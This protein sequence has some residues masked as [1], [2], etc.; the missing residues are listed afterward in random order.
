MIKV[1]VVRGIVK[2]H[3][4]VLAPHSVLSLY[5]LA[6]ISLQSPTCATISSTHPIYSSDLTI[7][8]ILSQGFFVLSP[9]MRSSSR[10]SCIL[11]EQ[12]VRDFW[13]V[14]SWSELENT[15]S[16]ANRYWKV[17]CRWIARMEL[18]IKKKSLRIGLSQRGILQMDFSINVVALTGKATARHL[19]VDFTENCSSRVKRQCV[20]FFFIEDYSPRDYLQRCDHQKNKS[21][22]YLTHG[23]FIERSL[24]M[25]Y[26]L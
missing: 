1:D 16:I 13:M 17:S 14:T 11:K 22:T 19:L 9:D 15:I 3:V 12:V 20:I 21:F 25:M 5:P 24:L 2:I 18:H 4:R 23:S 26:L 10:P 7:A 6:V 8:L